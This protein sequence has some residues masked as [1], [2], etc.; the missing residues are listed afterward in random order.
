MSMGLETDIEGSATET[1]WT[2]YGVLS[3]KLKMGGNSGWPDRLYC[4]P[5]GG[6]CFVEFK[7]GGNTPSARQRYIH[8]LLRAFGFAVQTHRDKMVAVRAILK[9][10]GLTPIPDHR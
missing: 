1:L 9:A 4:G 7:R 5:N 8:R 2:T 3:C 6:I 10:L